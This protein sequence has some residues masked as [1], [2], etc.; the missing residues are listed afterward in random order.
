M[1][2]QAVVAA[3]GNF[4]YSA[5]DSVTATFAKEQAAEI[6][7]LGDRTAGNLIEMGQRLKRVRD[8]FA[9][10]KTKAQ[11]RGAE[12]W[13]HWCETEARLG[14]HR[15]NQ[16]IKIGEKFAGRAIDQRL[17]IALLNYIVADVRD[18][19]VVDEVLDRTARGEVISVPKAKKIERERRLPSPAEARKKARASGAL[20]E[21]S[22]G[23]YYTG[24]SKQE[25]GAARRRRELVYQARDAIAD[26]ATL[27]LPA[28]K[29]LAMAKDW[30][31]WTPD[32]VHQI[33]TSIEW[34][35]DLKEVWESRYGPIARQH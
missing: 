16:L 4:D 14:R 32:E 7:A 35:T 9:S 33:V 34:L 3:G 13:D 26:L 25:A 15:V 12:T 17:G 28:E 5:I 27:D 23:F 18:P 24:A 21:A 8:R 31:V 22:D 1:S 29:L 20:V 6:R 30:Q 10:G 19:A 11:L 2:G